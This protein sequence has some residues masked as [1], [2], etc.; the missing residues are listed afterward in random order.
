ML[1][2]GRR[3]GGPKSTV[4]EFAP[5][6]QCTEVRAEH[7][8]N[9]KKRMRFGHFGVKRRAHNLVSRPCDGKPVSGEGRSYVRALCELR[10]SY[11]VVPWPMRT[12][13]AVSSG[14]CVTSLFRR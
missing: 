4:E 14:G 12:K 9:R 8:R 1:S 13:R 10:Y 2:G 3:V 6:N 5:G 11:N 7:F